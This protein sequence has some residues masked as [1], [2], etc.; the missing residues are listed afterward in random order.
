MVQQAI[1][2]SLVPAAV[3]MGLS[4]SLAFAG[5]IEDRQAAMKQNGK[6]MG[7]LVPMIKGEK[8]YDAAVVKEAATIL[9]EDGKKAAA[10]FPEGSDTGPPE[11]YVK[12]EIWSD[13][14][15]FKEAFD[16]A[17]AAAEALAMTTDEASFKA[18]FP[19]VG[20]SCGGCH[21]K[22]RRPKD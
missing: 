14:E 4:A 20:A 2:K 17:I 1:W 3:I 19:A 10:S 22:Y 15:G 9:V 8:P 11:T 16:K 21:E 7:M 5:P 13:P 6:A 12:A 18:A